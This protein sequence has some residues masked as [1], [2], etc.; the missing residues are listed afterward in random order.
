[1]LVVGA[2]ERP[3]R[4]H[5]ADRLALA[6]RRRHAGQRPP[7]PVG[8]VVHRRDPRRAEQLG[9]HPHHDLAVLQHVGDP[10]R[11]PAVVLQ[12]E[13]V[14]GPGPHQVDADDV[15]VD[16]ARRVDAD[17]RRLVGLVAIDE[18]GRDDPR[19]DDLRPVVDVPEEGVQRPRPLLHAAL[20]P[21]PLRLGEDPRHHVERD[22]PLGVAALAVD[23]EGDADAPEQ[24]LGLLLLLRR[25]PPARCVCTQS[26]QP[27]I[28]GPHLV[29]VEHLVEDADVGLPSLGLRSTKF[30]GLRKR[31]PDAASP[32]TPAPRRPDPGAMPPATSCP[33]SCAAPRRAHENAQ[34]RGGRGNCVAC[35]DVLNIRSQPK[36]TGIKHVGRTRRRGLR[37]I[38]ARAEELRRRDPGRQRPQPRRSARA[39]S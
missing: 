28:G 34:A 21:A 23:R 18:I 27:G 38:R 30:E 9:E 13:E 19:L 24:R 5:H 37:G 22:Q 17:H 1:M 36:P 20:Q 2:V 8:I 26:M 12:H 29:A 4:Q 35:G 6:L 16:P 33:N 7:Q 25:A 39:S 3:R 11:R 15:R 14:L 10:R 32:R 31:N